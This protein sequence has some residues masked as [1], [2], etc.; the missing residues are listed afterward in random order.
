MIFTAVI[1]LAAGLLFGLAPALRNTRT[2]IAENFEGRW[3]WHKQHSHRAQSIFV[4]V[5]MAMALVLLIG[6]GL[7]IRTMAH[8]WDRESRIQSAKSL[9]LQHVVAAIHDERHPDAVRADGRDLDAKWLRRPGVQE[10][11]ETWGAL[12]LSWDD[13][14]LFWLE[15]QPKPAS[16]NEMSWALDYIV[17]QATSRLWA[18]AATRPSFSRRKTTNTRRTW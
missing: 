2:G 3:P 15:G 4:V 16:Q 18:S 17:E 8:L 12:P 6:A 11:S 9:D 1:S 10:M 5:E 13:E 14:K 7:M